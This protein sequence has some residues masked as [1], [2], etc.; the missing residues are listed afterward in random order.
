MVD[1]I[2]LTAAMR[3]C[4]IVSASFKPVSQHSMAISPIQS[5]AGLQNRIRTLFVIIAALLV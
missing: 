4:F 3:Y 5:G 2:S 1:A